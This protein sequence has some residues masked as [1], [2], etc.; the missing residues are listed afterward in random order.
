N[1][2]IKVLRTGLYDG[3]GGAVEYRGGLGLDKVLELTRGRTSATYRGER[4]TLPPWGLFGGRP[5]RQSMARIV[6]KSGEVEEVASKATLKLHHGDQLHVFTAGGAG[7][8]DPLDRD[9][10]LVLQD[11]LDRRVSVESALEDYGVVIDQ[12]ARVVNLEE[13]A[14]E[15][16]R[17]RGERGDVTWT[18]DLGPELGQA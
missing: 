8:G 2:P 10:E 18:Y 1:F 5:G 14:K 3:S 6:R 16:R 4:H 13:T 12:E 9:P 15:R 17:R 7:Y 11:V